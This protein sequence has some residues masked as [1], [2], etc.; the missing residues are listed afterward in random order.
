MVDECFFHGRW[1]LASTVTPHKVLYTCALAQSSLL[2]LSQASLSLISPSF[3]FQA[4]AQ[5]ANLF[6]TCHEGRV[7]LQATSLSTQ[8]RW[9]GMLPKVLAIGVIFPYNVFQCQSAVSENASQSNVSLHLYTELAH[10]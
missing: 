8:T 3:P 5:L 7:L 6:A 4:P 1:S 2:L 10:P 9:P